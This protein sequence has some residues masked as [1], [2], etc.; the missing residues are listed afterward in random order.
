MC[1][2]GALMSVSMCVSMSVCVDIVGGGVGIMNVGRGSAHR[3]S[4]LIL[5]LCF[6]DG[7][8]LRQKAAPLCFGRKSTSLS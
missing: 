1:Q 2:C 6:G 3:S 8:R 7:V 5:P 4:T